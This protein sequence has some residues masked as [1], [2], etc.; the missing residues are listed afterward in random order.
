MQSKKVNCND[1]LSTRHKDIS[2]DL[3]IRTTSFAVSLGAG[4]C[5]KEIFMGGGGAIYPEAGGGGEGKRSYVTVNNC[6]VL[7]YL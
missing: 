7:G 2:Q 3:L 4:L 6:S 5:S 1:V